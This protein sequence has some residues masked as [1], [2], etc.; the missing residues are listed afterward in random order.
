MAAPYMPM[1]V[2]A[3]VDAVVVAVE[4]EA[5][6]GVGLTELLRWFDAYQDTKTAEMNEQREGRRYYHGKQW[7][8]QEERVLNE[9]KQPPVTN[10]CIAPKIDGIVG[11]VVRLR[12]DPKAS[13]RNEK[14]AAGAHIGTAAVREVLDENQWDTLQ[15]QIAQDLAIDGLGGIE[16]DVEPSSDGQP[17]VVLRRVAPET[18]FYDPR[19]VKADFSDARYLGV[20]KWMDLDSAIELMPDRADE[21]E[22]AIDRTTSNTA[23]GLQDWDKLWYDS[24]LKRVKVVE[25]WYRHKGDWW[26]A[27]HTGDLIL[28]E[29]LSPY[30]DQRGKTRCRYNMTSAGVDHEGNRYG[31]VRNMKSPQDEINHRRS[32]LLHILNVNQVIYEDGAVED[33]NESRKQLARPDGAVK[34]N[35]GG[36]RFEIRDQSQQMQGQAELLA[37]AKAEIE[38]FG[39]NQALLGSG[40]SSASGRAQAMQQ[41]AGIAQ[42]GPYFT[43]YKG[44][45]LDVYR[46]VW[47]DI[48][49]IWTN[50]RFIRVAGEDEVQFLPVNTMVMTPEGP[51]I[52]NA[53]GELD[54]DIVMDEGPDVVTLQEDVMMVVK[55]LIQQQL[56][57]PQTALKTVMELANLPPSVKAK[58]M[59]PPQPDPAQAQMQ[60]T[61]QQLE[62]RGAAAKIAL[63]EAQALKAQGDTE[64]AAAEAVHRYAQAQNAG[65]L[66][67]EHSVHTAR[68]VAD[69]A[70]KTAQT[71]KMGV[72]TAQME[73]GALGAPVG[74]Q[75][76]P[77][78]GF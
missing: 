62:M 4:P 68:A 12:Q 26:F 54:L 57:P 7:T 66:A 33:I 38:N 10:N 55:E 52:A 58:I 22:N 5:P 19:S 23:N 65:T 28:Q 50:E 78:L 34:V 25:I 1:G 43:R 27:I 39:P 8:D 64:L 45:K 67:D 3:G 11:V 32:K 30:A 41:Q 61:A 44:W 71:R 2:P 46:A 53:I 35:P 77:E 59:A 56:L 73:M 37:E 15:A 17:N 13:P 75:G 51:R 24:R 29:G 14:Q 6:K 18:F 76:Y 42:L 9:R 60:Q 48:Q 72:E 49:L 36:Q 16:R 47:A 21:L 40:A 31:F 69:I 70:H 63:T 74:P 20:Y